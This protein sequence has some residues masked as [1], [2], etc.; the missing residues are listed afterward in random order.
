MANRQG[1]LSVVFFQPVLSNLEIK[2][3]I[4]HGY[5]ANPTVSTR[6]LTRKA[7]LPASLFLWHDKMKIVN[8]RRRII[9]FMA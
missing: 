6:C 2:E 1:D 4:C 5:C 3:S 7:Y 8:V 9:F